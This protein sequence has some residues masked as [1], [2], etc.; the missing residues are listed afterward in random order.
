MRRRDEDERMPSWTAACGG[1]AGHRTAS[2]DSVLTRLTRPTR[3]RLQRA[4]TSAAAL[5]AAALFRRVAEPVDAAGLAR[6][7]HEWADGG[8]VSPLVLDVRSM[9]S[10]NRAHLQRAINI[11]VPAPLARR[12]QFDVATLEACVAAADRDA[13]R[14][15]TGHPVVLYGADGGPPAPN[16]S[17]PV[18]RA[19]QQLVAEGK[20]GH[21]YILTGAS[22]CVHALCQRYP[23]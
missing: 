9:F 22:A 4:A 17:E 10:Y 2:W 15:R 23:H 16:P 3:P 14:R 20:V 13:F 11:C 21:V 12:R 5:P 7:L 6:L 1:G 18:R 8:A 19:A